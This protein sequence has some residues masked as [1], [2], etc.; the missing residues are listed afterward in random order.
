MKPQHYIYLLWSL[1]VLFIGAIILRRMRRE[2]NRT[3]ATTNNNVKAF[4]ATIRRCEG[5]ADPRGYNTLFAY[6][7]FEDFSKHP[8]RKICRGNL[9]STAAGAYQILKRTWDGV[10]LKLGLDDFSPESQDI[11]AV[12]LIRGRGAYDDV[13]AG[14]FE[15]AVRKCNREWASLPGSPY[16]QPTHTLAQTKS[17]Y[18]NAGGQ[19]A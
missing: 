7:Y 10:A 9:C 1:L 8:N 13:L 11:A 5:T 19:F 15:T 18:T 17:Y 2:I 3:A 14:R 12:E 16:G 4:L 6:E